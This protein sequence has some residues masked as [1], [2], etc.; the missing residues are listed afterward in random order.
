MSPKSFSA[1]LTSILR[2]PKKSKKTIEY[3]LK[4][5][6]DAL[7]RHAHNI[8]CNRH[9]PPPPPIKKFMHKE[10]LFFIV[11]KCITFEARRFFPHKSWAQNHGKGHNKFPYMDNSEGAIRTCGKGQQ[12]YGLHILHRNCESTLI[13]FALTGFKP[14]GFQFSAAEKARKVW[15][16]VSLAPTSPYEST[17]TATF[18]KAGVLRVAVD[19][20]HLPFFEWRVLYLR[21]K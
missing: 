2:S 16:V 8:E 17:K 19:K 21:R 20:K 1:F 3:C 18:S 14:T 4:K 13:W 11:T 6:H 9:L 12:L 10:K 15:T 7:W 5:K